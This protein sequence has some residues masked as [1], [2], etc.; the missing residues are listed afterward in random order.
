MLLALLACSDQ[1]VSAL[2]FDAIA[3]VQGDF[4][5]VYEPLTALNINTQLYN[6]FIVQATYEPEDDRPTRETDANP[7]FEGLLTGTVD[8]GRLQINLFNAVFVNSGVRGLGAF[9]YND[10][11]EP[12]DAVLLDATAVENACK[13]VEGGGTLVVTDWGYDIVEACWPDAIEFF[14]D[15][16]VPDAAQAGMPDAAVLADVK[17]EAL[18]ESLGAS[19]NITYDYTAWSVIESVGGETEVLLSGTVEYQPSGDQL[20]V[21]LADAPLVVRFKPGRGQVVYSTFHWAAQTPDVSQKLL[22][23]GIEGLEEG[24]GDDSTDA[25]PVEGSGA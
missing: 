7:S 24:A 12:D 19:V 6:G 25:V 9:V 3:V 17:D 4:D 1:N 11:L 13:F 18:K 22:L 14:G 23:D 8:N 10:L 5:N 15:D 2:K 21:S 16:L 20:P